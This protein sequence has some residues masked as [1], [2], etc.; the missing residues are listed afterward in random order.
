MTTVAAKFS[1]ATTKFN[2]GTAALAI[3]AAAVLTPAVVA[4]AE[5]AGLAPVAQALGA[6]AAAADDTLVLP[7]L[8]NKQ[9]STARV[10]AAAIAGA[11][12][13]SSIF[14]NRFFWFGTPNPNPPAGTITIFEFTPLSLI[15]GFLRPLYSWFTQNINFQACVFGASVKIGP[16]GSLSGSVSSGGC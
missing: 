11:P 9:D 2:A 3:A 7:F 15:P 10:N 13:L 16:Y 6:A 5:P 12:A 4:N 8:D 1:G 14:Q